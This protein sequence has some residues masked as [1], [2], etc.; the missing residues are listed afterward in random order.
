MT[1]TPSEV[2]SRPGRTIGRV[3]EVFDELDST[4]Q[5]AAGRME[6]GLHGLTI[7]ARHQTAGRGQYGRSWLSVPDSSLL[8][9]IILEPAAWHRPV[10]LTA[11]AALGVA[12]LVED[13]T[14]QGPRIK[15]PND[16]YAGGR[17]VCGILSECGRNVV[18]GIGLNLSQTRDEFDRAELPLATSLAE[19]GVAEPSPVSAAGMLLDRLDELYPAIAE[20]RPDIEREWVSRLGLQ[21]RRAE[22][23]E[24]RGD[25]WT[26]RVRALGFD[27]IIFESIDGVVMQFRPDEVRNITPIDPSEQ[28]A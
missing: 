22:L 14:G 13:L 15:W 23:T 19:L 1:S 3:V 26:G 24:M 21:G 10:L 20:S 28:A 4:N 11:W 9:S 18:V 5:F 8:M 27:G 7:V 6:L 17:K 16:I 25:R 12:R 2:I